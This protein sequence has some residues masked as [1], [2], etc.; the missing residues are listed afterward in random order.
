MT[1]RTFDNRQETFRVAIRRFDPFAQ[2]IPRQWNDFV[3]STGCRLRLEWE[4]L[5]LNPLVD[6]LFTR[7]GL[8]DGTWDVAFIITDRL[9]EAVESEALRDLTPHMRRQ[10]MPDYPQGWS[11][12]LTTMR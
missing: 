12:A 9:T 1:A 2:S 4:M 10:P 8:K 7:G 3:E 6:S 5:D 11:P